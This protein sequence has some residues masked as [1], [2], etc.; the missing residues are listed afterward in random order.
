MSF[1]SGFILANL[2]IRGL[3]WIATCIFVDYCI[4]CV[5]FLLNPSANEKWHKKYETSKVIKLNETCFL[6]LILLA[7]FFFWK[8][9]T[10]QEEVLLEILRFGAVLV[11]FCCCHSLSYQGIKFMR[12]WSLLAFSPHIVFIFIVSSKSF[13]VLCTS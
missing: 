10:K 8:C 13:G 7:L 4:F 3:R 9:V 6:P 2:E 5:L 11:S 12:P 1:I